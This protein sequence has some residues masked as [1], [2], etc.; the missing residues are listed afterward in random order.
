[1][2]KILKLN[3]DVQGA[4]QNIFHSA[5]ELNMTLIGVI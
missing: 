1:M 2:N 3:E 4:V 5:S